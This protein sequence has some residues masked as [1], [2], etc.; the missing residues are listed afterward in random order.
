MPWPSAAKWTCP[1]GGTFYEVS[2][3]FRSYA[4]RR[5]D[6]IPKFIN[7]GLDVLATSAL[8]LLG[9]LAIKVALMDGTFD[10][11]ER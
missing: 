4:G 2:R 5:V 10:A 8:D 3:L 6:E 9:S 1:A 11:T 7:T